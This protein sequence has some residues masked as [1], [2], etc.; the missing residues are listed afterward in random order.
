MIEVKIDGTEA[1]TKEDIY[2]FKFNE[3]MNKP[4][5][6]ENLNKTFGLK[7][8]YAFKI[9]ESIMD[10]FNSKIWRKFVPVLTMIYGDRSRK[11]GYC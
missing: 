6:K 7:D 10:S 2:E 8:T 3:F 11:I 1:T 9:R 5:V 4:F